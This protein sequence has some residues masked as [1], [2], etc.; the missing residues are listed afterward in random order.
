MVLL[1]AVIASLLATYVAK[2][3]RKR[4]NTLLF[5][6]KAADEDHIQGLQAE[7]DAYP[8]KPFNAEELQIRI[9]MLLEQRR[10]LQGKY[11]PQRLEMKDE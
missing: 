9:E 4:A 3:R 1:A 11:R 10:V 2:M 5:T 8:C 6:A 7:A